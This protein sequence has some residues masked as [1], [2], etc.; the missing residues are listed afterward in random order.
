MNP[1]PPALSAQAQQG[2]V[3]IVQK[4]YDTMAEYKKAEEEKLA[5]RRDEPVVEESS[6]RRRRKAPSTMETAELTDVT[7]E[8][9]KLCRDSARASAHIGDGK[10]TVE[11]MYAAARNKP[12]WSTIQTVLRYY[13][14][15][16]H[17]IYSQPA[18]PRFYGSLYWVIADSMKGSAAEDISMDELAARLGGSGIAQTSQGA[19][20]QHIVYDGIAAI[21]RYVAGHAESKKDFQTLI[22]MLTNPGHAD[23]AVRRILF[24]MEEDKDPS[25]TSVNRLARVMVWLR[26]TVD[27]LENT[28]TFLSNATTKLRKETDELE[29]QPPSTERNLLVFLSEYVLCRAGYIGAN[30]FNE[31][32]RKA[33]AD[34][35]YALHIVWSPVFTRIMQ[36]ALPC[37][38]GTETAL[39]TLAPAIN[40]IYGPPESLLAG[41][42]SICV[43]GST[44]TKFEELAKM[45]VSSAFMDRSTE[46]L[47]RQLHDYATKM[48]L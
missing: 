24:S 40:A 19:S 38:P 26:L 41:Q 36:L 35:R 10:V 34:N 11:A 1:A 9:D 29:K 8:Q 43:D 46:S 28:M 5:S 44:K 13:V 14:L 2:Y 45:A 12:I 16:L 48:E 7:V 15:L 6:A 33:Y 47:A 21:R 39:F 20:I 18:F 23:S 17:Y 31:Y 25:A 42:P 3:D 27:M 30:S 22:R 37:K 4:A 32:Q